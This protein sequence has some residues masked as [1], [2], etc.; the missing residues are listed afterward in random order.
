MGARIPNIKPGKATIEYLSKVQAS[1]RFWGL[2]LVKDCNFSLISMPL[3][4][5]VFFLL[6]GVNSFPFWK[7]CR[8]PIIRC[9][10][11]YINCSWSLFAAYQCWIC[12][13][14]YISSNYCKWKKGSCTCTLHANSLIILIY[15]ARNSWQLY[16]S[17]FSCPWGNLNL[18]ELNWSIMLS[19]FHWVLVD[20]AENMGF[21]SSFIFLNRVLK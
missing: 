12:Y 6:L 11:H 21:G 15:Q 3:L 13:W 19:H 8:G 20:L 16:V 2:L 5:A 10:S 4:N 1:T 18:G 7:F 17:G 14:F 9:I